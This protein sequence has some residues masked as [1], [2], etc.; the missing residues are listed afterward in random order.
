MST[1]PVPRRRLA[2]QLRTMRDA[3]GLT[4]EQAAKKL[5]LSKSALGRIEVG[6][7]LITVHIIRSMM[8]VY[9]QYEPDVLEMVRQAREPGWW[10]GYRIANLDY[11]AWE[12][13]A[14][15]A[16]ELAVARIPDL[17]QTEPYAQAW[18][19]VDN[20]EEHDPYTVRRR[21]DDEM[22]SRIVRQQRFA[23]PSP[24]RLTTVI[25][26]AA[27][28][29]RVASAQVMLSQWR[30]LARAA[31]WQAV[32]LRV[33]RTAANESALCTGAFSLLG[34]AEPDDPPQLYVDSP[35]GLLRQDKPYQVKQA[36][37]MFDRLFAASLSE[38]D[39]IDF[40]ECLARDVPVSE[41]AADGG[42]V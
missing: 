28:R 5:E 32:N 16:H 31:T 26:E 30:H 19:S 17:L 27:L 3:A 38:R 34:F 9:D 12:T 24:I 33:L 37:Y 40:I 13:C 29:K 21:V 42:G 15:T 25:T 22:M 8:D 7:T 35:V 23:G 18:L 41:L 39:S 11:L 1:A 20:C 36:R 4:L 6:Q 10:Q 14:D 2:R